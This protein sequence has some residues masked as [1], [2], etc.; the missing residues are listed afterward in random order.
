MDVQ[1]VL[2]GKAITASS[3]LVRTVTGLGM[4]ALLA[5]VAPVALVLLAALVLAHVVSP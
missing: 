3:A 4:P 1:V 2:E 5:L